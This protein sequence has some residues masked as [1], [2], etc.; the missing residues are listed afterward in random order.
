VRFLI[1]SRILLL[2]HERG[3]CIWLRIFRFF[4]V[5]RICRVNR[6]ERKL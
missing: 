1:E 6:F 5:L 3:R 2:K 4:R